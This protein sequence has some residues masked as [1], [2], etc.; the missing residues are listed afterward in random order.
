MKK[1]LKIDFRKNFKGKKILITGHTGFK[2]SWLSLCMHHNGAKV[3]GISDRVPT[4]PSH[5]KLIGLNKKI[6]SKLFDITNL[7]K[8]KKTFLKFK[9]DYVFHLAAQAIVKVSYENPVETWKTNLIG[10][11]NILECLR[12]AKKKTT[13]VIITSD[14]A[15]KNLEINRGYTE[16]DVL[17]GEDPYGASKSSADI[18]VNSYFNSF[19]LYKEKKVLITIA[20][21]G[22]VIGGGDWSPNRIITDCIKS[23]SKNKTVTIRSPKSTRPWQHVLDVIFGYMK[24]AVKLN[25]NPKL[26]GEAFNFGPDKNNLKVIDVLKKIKEQWPHVKWT[27][28]KKNKFKENTLLHLN[29]KKSKKL[30]DWS[31]VLN[32]N[33][34]IKFTVEWYQNFL[35]N[36]KNM[37]KFSLSQI[38]KYQEIQ[39][40]KNKKF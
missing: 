1:N 16:K 4:N 30:L 39:K 23:W 25:K 18:A 11:V 2:G 6:S 22:N 12:L 24:L 10:T 5:F 21:A 29:C 14:K 17:K 19:F 27:V 9:P 13:A 34:S 3:L 20:R 31:N 37:Y 28:K 33:N 38:S 40:A 36:K 15:Y 35:K 32:F 8:L 26:H 7:N